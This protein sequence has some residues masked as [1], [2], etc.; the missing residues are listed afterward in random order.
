[1]FKPDK[2]SFCKLTKDYNLIPVYRT[3]P[4]DLETPVSV[5][6]KTAAA[7]PGSFLLESGD[8]G[9]KARYSF[10]GFDPFMAVYT[11]AE[12]TFIRDEKGSEKKVQG[13]PL[14]ALEKIFAEYEIYQP[15]DIAAFWGGAVGYLSY[16]MVRSWENIPPCGE[17]NS[18]PRSCFFFPR[19]V[20]VY[21]H[22]RHLLTVIYVVTPGNKKGETSGDSA[23]DYRKAVEEINH[24]ILGLKNNTAT[25]GNCNDEINKSGEDNPVIYPVKKG[26]KGKKNVDN[27]AF[28]REDFA[29]AVTKAGEYIRAGDIFQVVLSR[30]V[31]QKL[32]VHP[33]NLYRALRSLNPSPYQFYLSFNGFQI[34]GASPEMLV[35]LDKGSAF[36]RPIA[37]TRPRGADD[38]ADFTLA[39]ELSGDEKE[40]AE[41]MMLVDLGRNDLGRV[42][43]YG[44]VDVVK[45]LEVEYFSHVIHLV[46]EVT[47]KIRQGNT[48]AH[49]LR[50]AFP[51]G[52]VSGA[53]KV[54]AMEIISELEPVSRG[55]YAGAVG[56][57][58]FNGVMDTCIAIR[59]IITCEG[60]AQI[61]AGAGIVAD[62]DPAREFEETEHKMAAS[63]R[64]LKLAEEW[65]K[66]DFNC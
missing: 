43:E 6:L 21:D 17:D 40:R 46:S 45:L 25:V 35:S 8:L 61:Q 34:L 18:L 20:L 31:T 27:H 62:S 49:L 1:M 37:G 66:N 7:W 63:L 57:I 4:A 3:V 29:R 14:Q 47:G 10:I 41:H 26:G 11:E 32:R 19:R 50:A 33:F 53:P 58:G 13:D 60:V 38:A 9:E 64:A 54:R 23:D 22:R 39:G 55:P 59:T 16:D 28:K 42:C 15:D 52:T 56:Y 36:T 48:F 2:D 65:E 5:Y 44:T 51:A 24:I 12:N 30:R